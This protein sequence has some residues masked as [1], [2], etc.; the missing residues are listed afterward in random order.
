MP[1]KKGQSGNKHGRPRGVQNRTTK[2]VRSLAQA[3]FDTAYWARTKV[4]LANDTLHPA[5]H[6]A[7][8]AYAYGEP[9][10]TLTV[11]G[12]IGIREK[13]RVLTQLPDDVVARIAAQA[14]FEDASADDGPVN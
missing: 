1:F 2:D 5:I 4:L 12:E 3:L 13:R 14:A 11:E 10:K 6:R 9:K 7:L 8:L